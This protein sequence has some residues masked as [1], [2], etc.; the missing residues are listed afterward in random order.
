M[1]CIIRTNIAEHYC[2]VQ[3]KV[4]AVIKLQ[5]QGERI[6]SI[7]TCRAVPKAIKLAKGA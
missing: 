2:S 5:K 3:D 1:Y 7:E 6:V 4:K